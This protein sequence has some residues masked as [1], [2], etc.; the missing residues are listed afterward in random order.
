LKKIFLT[1]L[2][3]VILLPTVCFAKVNP[4]NGIKVGKP[5]MAIIITNYSN[6]KAYP[7]VLNNV[8]KTLRQSLHSSQLNFVMDD[9]STAMMEYLEEKKIDDIS[10]LQKDDLIEFGNKYKYS[11]VTMLEFNDIS[12]RQAKDNMFFSQVK[13]YR[14]SSNM[15]VKTID[16]RDRRYSYRKEIYQEGMS[17]SMETMMPMMVLLRHEHS[18]D[19]V[20]AFYH[21]AKLPLTTYLF[22]DALAPKNDPAVISGWKQATEKC[23]KEFVAVTNEKYK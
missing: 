1:L 17:T 6:L 9:A 14:I 12:I 8:V 3:L 2:L 15:I 4:D 11:Y 10:K 16:V 22:S 20:D 7:V 19:D 21:G 5:T 18:V 13:N 23:I